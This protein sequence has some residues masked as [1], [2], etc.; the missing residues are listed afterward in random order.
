MKKLIV[1]LILSAVLA[2]CAHEIQPNGE[3]CWRYGISEVDNT[4]RMGI[5]QKNIPAVYLSYKKLLE[6]CDVEPE[7]VSW[8]NKNQLQIRACYKPIENVIYEY[9]LNYFSNYFT[10]HE[11]CHQKLGREH[12]ACWGKGYAQFGATIEEA[13]EWD[14]N[15]EI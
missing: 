15:K 12:N 1:I 11:I 14:S 8:S 3:G 7:P 6:A 13:C 5:E 9:R 2:G 4:G 10:R